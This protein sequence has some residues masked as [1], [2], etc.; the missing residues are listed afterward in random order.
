M[1]EI[2]TCYSE[3][4]IEKANCGLDHLHILVSIPPKMSVSLFVNVLKTNTANG[5][6]QK[7]E[8]LKKL[9]WGTQ[10]I[11]SIG[12]FVSTVGINESVIKRYIEF[13]GQEDTGQAKLEL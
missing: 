13:Q 2:Q 1:K 10:S 4:V 12:Y 11:W 3:I 5:L 9:Y 8:F 6:K 7:F